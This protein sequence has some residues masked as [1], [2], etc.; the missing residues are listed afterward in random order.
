MKN[1]MI[2]SITICLLVAACPQAIGEPE[3]SKCPKQPQEP[4]IVTSAD[5]SAPATAA[6][7]KTKLSIAG[8]MTKPFKKAG[9]SLK[10]GAHAMAHHVSQATIKLGDKMAPYQNFMNFAGSL[11][12]VVTSVGILSGVARGVKL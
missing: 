10:R 9:S 8:K 4:A 7:T 3:E 1:L 6:K 5:L 11:G 2:V 12:S